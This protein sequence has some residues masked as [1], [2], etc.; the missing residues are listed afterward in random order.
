[1]LE[2]VA[3]VK[4]CKSRYSRGQARVFLGVTALTLGGVHSE[5]EIPETLERLRAGS[6]ISRSDTPGQSIS[7][8]WLACWR[9][10]SA[11]CHKPLTP[12]SCSV[13]HMPSSQARLKESVHVL[14]TLQD[15]GL[16]WGIGKDKEPI[17]PHR[18]DDD[19]P[20]LVRGHEH[21]MEYP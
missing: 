14:R 12:P 13:R 19:L 9:H 17:L 7:P 8:F 16:L 4:K 15:D 20:D 2:Y 10:S 11:A 21:A 1:M 5:V 6:P 3:S 18:I